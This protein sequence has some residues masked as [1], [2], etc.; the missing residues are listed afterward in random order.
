MTTQQDSKVRLVALENLKAMCAH[1]SGWAHTYQVTKI[2]RSRVHVEYSNPDEYGNARPMTA[3]FPAYPSN[4]PQDGAD[5]PRVV[6]DPIRMYGHSPD[7]QDF[8]LLESCPS[9]WRDYPQP[10]V[11]RWESHSAILKRQGK[12]E[13]ENR[14]PSG[15]C[16]SCTVCD[17]K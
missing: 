3:V 7:W 10:N 5:N 14:T 2:T 17:V 9:V 15:N 12:T 6:L 13:I 4:W 1:V 16:P 11:E 8:Y